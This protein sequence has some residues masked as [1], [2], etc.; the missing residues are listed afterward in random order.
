MF[1]A[2]EE[3]DKIVEFIRDYY[4]KSNCKGAILGMT[5]AEIMSKL[6]EEFNKQCFNQ[7]KTKSILV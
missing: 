4:K 7:Y 1:N 2:K 5:K 6:D 3:K